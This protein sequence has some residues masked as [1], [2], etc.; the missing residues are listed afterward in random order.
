[1]KLRISSVLLG[2]LALC[3]SASCSSPDH[4]AGYIPPASKKW[5]TFF[6]EHRDEVLGKVKAQRVYAEISRE[7]LKSIIEALL[8]AYKDE[9][10]FRVDVKSVNGATSTGQSCELPYPLF[11]TYG[12]FSRDASQKSDTV[13]NSDPYSVSPS[14]Q[15]QVLLQDEHFIEILRA[16]LE[17]L[18]SN[19]NDVKIES[20]DPAWKREF[21]IPRDLIQKGTIFFQCKSE[22]VPMKGGHRHVDGGFGLSIRFVSPS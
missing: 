12:Q 2:L 10:D 16:L 18:R 20:R 4:D 8:A 11:F 9:R 14:L 5:N 3:I 17:A 22:P 6:Q 13:S 21:T 7:Q 1:M 15:N 19:S